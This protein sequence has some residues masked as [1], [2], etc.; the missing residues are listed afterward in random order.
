MEKQ[1]Q[2]CSRT[3][4]I[5][6]CKRSI[7]I[8]RYRTRIRVEREESGFLVARWATKRSTGKGKTQITV[9]GFTTPF[10]LSQLSEAYNADVIFKA[11]SLRRMKME[12][13]FAR[14]TNLSYGIHGPSAWKDENGVVVKVAPRAC[15]AGISAIHNQVQSFSNVPSLQYVVFRRDSRLLRCTLCLF[16]RLGRHCPRESSTIR[17]PQAWVVVHSRVLSKESGTS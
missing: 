6:I 9:S 5:C 13:R 10:R 2:P 12:A 17:T 7:P 11:R 15:V 16:R 4:H 1:S 8:R 3:A 14:R